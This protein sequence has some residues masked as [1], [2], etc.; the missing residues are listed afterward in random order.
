MD[1]RAGSACQ[2]DLRWARRSG[3]DVSARGRRESA[4]TCRETCLEPRR[5]PRPHGSWRRG[6]RH[7]DRD[8]PPCRQRVPRQDRLYVS[9]EGGSSSETVRKRSKALRQCPPIR[10]CVRSVT[11]DRRVRATLTRIYR[12]T[13]AHVAETTTRPPRLLHRAFREARP[14]ANAVWPSL[15]PRRCDRA[16]GGSSEPRASQ[17]AASS[18]GRAASCSAQRRREN[19]I[20]DAPRQWRAEWPSAE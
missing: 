4:R 3:R 13:C 19:R 11:E 5:L 9:P 12:T 15:D 2:T 10:A 7:H 1:D 8:R 6:R 20:R 17:R 16:R 14:E 18:R